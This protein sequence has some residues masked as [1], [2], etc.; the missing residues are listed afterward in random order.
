MKKTLIALMALAG[1]SFADTLTLNDTFYTNPNTWVYLWNST[2]KSYDILGSVGDTEL[3]TG[4]GYTPSANSGDPSFYG[5]TFSVIDGVQTLTG[6]AEAIT[7]A[8]PTWVS[9]GGKGIYISS[10]VTLTGADNGLQANTNIHFGDIASSQFDYTDRVWKRGVANVYGSLTLSDVAFSH[11]FF[12]VAN[13]QQNDGGWNFSN[14]SVTD[15]NGNALTYT[16]DEANIGKAG[17]FWVEETTYTQGSSYSATLVAKA[18]PEPT[19][20][21]LSLLALAGLAAR[22]RR[23]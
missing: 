9:G 11:T 19:T 4:S 23:R 1:V 13:M 3:W 7:I 15:A 16:T 20:A 6:S 18:I 14:F 17:Y 2:T 12:S 21:T 10:N 8:A 22:R 5:Y